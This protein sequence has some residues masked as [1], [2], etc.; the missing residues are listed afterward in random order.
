MRMHI[1]KAKISLELQQLT[2]EHQGC[3]ESLSLQTKPGR[4]AICDQESGCEEVG[5]DS[6]HAAC[7]Q[8]DTG[9]HIEGPNLG[10]QD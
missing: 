7:Q 4:A 6:D 1:T 5:A 2:E 8:P 10:D 3:Y 9:Q